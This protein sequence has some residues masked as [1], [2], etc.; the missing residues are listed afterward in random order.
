MLDYLP[1]AEM[2]NKQKQSDF[3]TWLV[4]TNLLLRVQFSFD[5]F[6]IHVQMSQKNCIF[7]GFLKTPYLLGSTEPLSKI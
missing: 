3:L 6:T 4:V 5:S 2:W 1:L 7:P